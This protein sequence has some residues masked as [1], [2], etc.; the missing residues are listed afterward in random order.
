MS[1]HRKMLKHNDAAV[2]NG[3]TFFP[4]GVETFG[5][6]GLEATKLVNV[7]AAHV[8]NTGFTRQL[9]TAVQV[10]LQRHNVEMV[11]HALNLVTG[12]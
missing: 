6:L 11:K 7:L 3:H 10:A 4:F 12:E 5:R 8:N 1:E 9:V 2:A